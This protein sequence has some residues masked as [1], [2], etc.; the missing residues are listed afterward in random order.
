MLRLFSIFD[1]VDG[2]ANAFSGIGEIS[3]FVRFYGCNLRCWYCDSMKAV[4]GGKFDTLKVDECYDRIMEHNPRKLTITG[5]EPLMQGPM[6][7]ELLLELVVNVPYLKVSIE[8]SGSMD[9]PKKLMLYPDNIRFVADFKPPS[10]GRR[11][12][13]KD[14]KRLTT[15][16]RPVDLV[17][18]VFVKEDI[19]Y[20]KR[21]IAGFVKQIPLLL[22]P[23]L[24]F[25]AV[26]PDKRSVE[27]IKEDFGY[28]KSEILP[29]LSPAYFNVI[30]YVQMHKIL[31]LDED[32]SDDGKRRTNLYKEE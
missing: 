23:K 32:K 16:L 4:D 22:P 30:F 2:E 6:L 14:I 28:L 21:C 11:E 17:K 20:I 26:D 10:S 13:D 1:T 12:W 18:F 9:F 31:K 27:E 8:T 7:V 24:A 29:L 5:G 19:P 3:T 15:T 25:S